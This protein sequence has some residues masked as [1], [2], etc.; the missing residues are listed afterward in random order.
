[1]QRRDAR[2]FAALR[3]SFD[4]GRMLEL[5]AF[6]MRRK[7]HRGVRERH[8][9]FVLC[10]LRSQRAVVLP[11]LGEFVARRERHLTAARKRW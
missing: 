7:R 11:E 4:H 9:G 2:W 5:D 10:G 6:V 8:C 3:S 1:M